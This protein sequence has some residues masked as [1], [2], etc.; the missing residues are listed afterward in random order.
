MRYWKECHS[1]VHD[2]PTVNHFTRA[3]RMG[4]AQSYYHKNGFVFVL[5]LSIVFGYKTENEVRL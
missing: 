1:C 3:Q 5:Q 2:V 4:W